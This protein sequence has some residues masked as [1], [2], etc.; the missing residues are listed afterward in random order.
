MMFDLMVDV[1]DRFWQLR[2]AHTE[3]AVPLL[4][5]EVSQFPEGLMNP[6]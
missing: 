5:S 6:G 4:P 2:N 1:T 3:C